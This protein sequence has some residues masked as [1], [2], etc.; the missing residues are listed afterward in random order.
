MDLNSVILSF[1]VVTIYVY[2][3]YIKNVTLFLLYSLCCVSFLFDI[4]F[5]DLLLLYF[6]I[7][8]YFCF[9]AGGY[10]CFNTCTVILIPFL[11]SFLKCLVSLLSVLISF[12][13]YLIQV[14]YNSQWTNSTFFCP[15]F[16]VFF[17]LFVRA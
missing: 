6:I 10:L 3:I 15:P 1:A 12:D 4:V 14:R 16:S 9:N 13:S 5:F 11:K 17:L 7:G 2:Y 8:K